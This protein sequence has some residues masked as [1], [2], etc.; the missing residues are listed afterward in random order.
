MHFLA[1]IDPVL[2]FLRLSTVELVRK[3]LIQIQG[4]HNE[5]KQNSLFP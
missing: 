2:S 3:V 1:R 5:M 4:L